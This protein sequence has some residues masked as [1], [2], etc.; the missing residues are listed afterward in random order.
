MVDDR[1]RAVR[2][3]AGDWRESHHTAC[4][5]YLA[6]HTAIIS[7]KREL[8]IVSCG[9]LPYDINLIQAHKAID[10]AAHA[11]VEGGTIVVLAECGDGVGHPAFL[12]WFLEKDSRALESRLR[13]SY[14]VNGQTAWALL[15]KTE[16]YHIRL[17][18]KLPDDAVRRMRI[19][20]SRSLGD[21]LEG[22]NP[23]AL[24]YVLP[25]GAAVLPQLE[26]T[27]I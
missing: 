10:M 6:S 18:S 27:Q 12:K 21:A 24:G 5:A 4:R 14:E 15:V 23:K 20:P 19:I 2:I 22:V 25:R 13:E 7:A 1:G 17:V 16:R 8:V 11:C 3:D 9:G 26:S